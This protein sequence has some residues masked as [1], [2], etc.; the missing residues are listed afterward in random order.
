MSKDEEMLYFTVGDPE[1]TV[2]HADGKPFKPFGDSYVV[3][4]PGMPPG[5]GRVHWD[6]KIKIVRAEELAVAVD[7][8][9]TWPPGYYDSSLLDGVIVRPLGSIYARAM[10][11][12]DR[13]RGT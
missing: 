4:E 13:E 2:R 8:P 10:E 7:W 6:P 12:R 1:G 3:R 11:Q 9:G 5:T